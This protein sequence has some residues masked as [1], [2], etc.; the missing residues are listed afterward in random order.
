M[1]ASGPRIEKIDASR[2][3]SMTWPRPPFISTLRTA[4]TGAIAPDS[5]AIMSAMASGGGTGSRPSKALA[6]AEAA[7]PPTRAPLPRRPLGRVRADA[8]HRRRRIGLRVAD[9][10]ARHVRRLRRG[11]AGAGH[12]VGGIQL[13]RAQ[14]DARGLPRAPRADAD[15]GNGGGRVGLR[16]PDADARHRLRRWRPVLG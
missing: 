9:A 11:D 7:L 6:Q 13:R 10:D 4:M 8:G 2:L 3:T 5:P 12:G 1:A 14:P 15:A 16:R